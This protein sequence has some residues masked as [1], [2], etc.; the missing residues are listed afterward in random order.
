MP[1]PARDRAAGRR[2]R[3]RRRRLE[4][5]REL[6]GQRGD[7]RPGAEHLERR[8]CAERGAPGR[9]RLVL[10]DGRVL[11]T[12][13]DGFVLSPKVCPFATRAAEIFDPATGIWTRTGDL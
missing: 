10:P 3:A 1:R 5:R 13:G 7:L 6:Y 4:R 2:A 8:R 12:G 11:V 9:R